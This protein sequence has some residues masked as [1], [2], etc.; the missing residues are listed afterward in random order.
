MNTFD[1]FE[2]IRR[3]IDPDDS[4]PSAG[5]STEKIT[6][7]STDPMASILAQMSMLRNENVELRKRVDKLESMILPLVIES[8]KERIRT[9]VMTPN[10]DM[11]GMRRPDSGGGGSGGSSPTRTGSVS[12]MG[13]LGGTAFVNPF[14]TI[15]TTPT[16]VGMP[17]KSNSAIAQMGYVGK[18][19]LW[20]TAVASYLIGACRYYIAKTN[21][22]L[23]TIDEGLLMK[24][25][26]AIVSTLYS[27]MAHKDLPA[28][29]DPRSTY[30]AKAISRLDKNDVPVSNAQT[31]TDMIKTQDGDD[32]VTIINIII[33]S[34]KRA[35]EAVAHPVSQIIPFLVVP[36]SRVVSGKPIFAMV[37]SG[38]VSIIPTRWEHWCSILKDNALTKHIQ[39]RMAGMTETAVVSK[40]VTEM[41]PTDL[42]RERQ[43]DGAPGRDR[44]RQPVRDH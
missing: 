8:K 36:I 12:T 22:D 44:V 29:K 34:A 27:S 1:N 16:P 37:P 15:N 32:V 26:T 2:E 4:G 25:M 17:G 35:P 9:R 24:N 10:R 40:M 20:G 41:R 23:I 11:F 39:Y 28:V 5:P 38:S 42:D 13:P 33:S 21:S 3:A 19:Q 30:L 6:V 43:H 18:K 14:E 7:M 31:W